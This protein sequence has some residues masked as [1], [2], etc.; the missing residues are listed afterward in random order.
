MPRQI[1]V[2]V[3]TALSLSDA[4]MQ[5]AE[6]ESSSVRGNSA[7]MIDSISRF[8]VTQKTEGVAELRYV[9]LDPNS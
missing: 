2:E 5:K 3:T 1:D 6:I 4:V 7:A 9:P 8:V